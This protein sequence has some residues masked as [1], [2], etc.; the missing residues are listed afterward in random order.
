MNVDDYQ[1]HFSTVLF[2]WDAPSGNSRIDYYHYQ[3]TNE[4]NVIA[5]NTTNTSVA[6]LGIPYNRN[7]TFS[8]SAVNCVGGSGEIREVVNIG[9]CIQPMEF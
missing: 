4:T 5:Y 1:S 6:I 8:L 9:K 2:T 3:L 7:I